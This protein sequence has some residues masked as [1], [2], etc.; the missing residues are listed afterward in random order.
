MGRLLHGLASRWPIIS[1]EGMGGFGKTTLAI[2]TAHHCLA[3]PNAQLE[4][5]FE[6]IVWIS[7]KARP[8]KKLWL[9]EV[10]GTV[11]CVL[12]TSILLS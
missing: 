3:G 1:I 12:D 10:L 9:N 6:A 5:P 11:A 8:E 2:E 4:E 7:A